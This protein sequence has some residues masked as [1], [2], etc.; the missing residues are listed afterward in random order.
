MELAE[1][2]KLVD[3]YDEARNTR[4][5]ADKKAKDLKT[6][7]AKFADRITIELNGQGIRYAAGTVKRVKLTPHTKPKAEDWP[8]FYEYMR[9]ENAFDLLQKRLGEA[10][11]MLR[12]D[13][14]IVIPGLAFNQFFKLS[15]G[16]ID[17][18]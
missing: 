7:E 12:R 14:G 11:I 4:L 3:Q 9:E 17:N 6:I 18:G 5:A 1:L 2:A 13:E 15:L 10:A 8:K 16:K